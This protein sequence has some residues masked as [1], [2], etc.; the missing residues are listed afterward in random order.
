MNNRAFKI[1][2]LFGLISA[3]VLP[4]FSLS[5]DENLE[6]TCR[7]EK[8]ETKPENFS[9]EEYETLL[10]KCQAYYQERS[11]EIK[12][13]IN[14]TEQ[15]KDTL[16]RQINLLKNKVQNLEYQIYQSNIVIKDLG[17]QIGDTEFSIKDTSLKI[18]ETC[19][20]LVEILRKVNEEDQRSLVEVLLS[21]GISDFFNNL[22]QLDALNIRNQE[23]LENIKSLKSY[24]EGQK[25]SLDEE[26][27]ELE[28]SVY[29][30]NLQKQES[31]KLK[32][33]QEG[34][35]KLTEAQY[36]KQLEEREETEKRVAEI[37]SRLFELIGV[38]EG[39]IEFGKAVEIA[40]YVERATGVRS[41]FLLAVIAQESMRYGKFGG[42]VGQCYLKN[43]LT[44]E[45][46]IINSGETVSRVMKPMGLYGRKGDIDDFLEITKELGRDPYNTPVSCPW[47]SGWGGAMG[48]AQFI[49][50]TWVLYKDKIT[51]IT[52]ELADPWKIKDSF[53][54]SGSFLADLGASKQ[55]YNTE[56]AAAMRYYSGTAKR[57]K[58]NGYGFYGDSVMSRAEEYQKE[59]NLLEESK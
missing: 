10:K 56:W 48:P 33:E 4:G 59:I 15:E 24:L 28:N 45:G 47:I 50:T 44:G 57:T 13:D 2:L 19:G 43:R 27:E 46:I 36:Q 49:P 55:T 30:Q 42:N 34:F 41:A 37:T 21:E 25:E 39:G 1:F 54:A 12:K 16:Q 14:K 18:E 52:G 11:E 58:Y 40:Q 8:I 7:W 17:I 6:E 9:E 20:G 29:I 22:V 51:A 35:L 32:S 3:F 5:A 23:L 26:K 31:S 38:A 53:M